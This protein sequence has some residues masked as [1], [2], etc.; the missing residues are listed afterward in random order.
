MDGV[1]IENF[2]HRARMSRA[3]D[4]AVNQ[5]SALAIVVHGKSDRR[6]SWRGLSASARAHDVG[7]AGWRCGCSERGR[8]ANV[9]ARKSRS[10]SLSQFAVAD[11]CGSRRENSNVEVRDVNAVQQRDARVVRNITPDES[12]SPRVVELEQA[13]VP[14]TLQLLPDEIVCRS[15][16]DDGDVVLRFQLVDERCRA[17]ERIGCIDVGAAKPRNAHHQSIS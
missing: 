14:W 15:F 16:N 9:R 1:S 4:R 5:L 7:V 2:D 3:F 12:M 11:H 8:V 13:Q 10:Q 17:V 6:R